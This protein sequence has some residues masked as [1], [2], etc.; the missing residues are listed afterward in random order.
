MKITS[1]RSE[2]ADDRGTAASLVPEAPA[3]ADKPP[4]DRATDPSLLPA[5]RPP[6]KRP[7]RIMPFLITL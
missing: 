3:P 2:A 1:K 4:G 7:M 5:A 6:A